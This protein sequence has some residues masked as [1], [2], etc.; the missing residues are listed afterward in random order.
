[1]RAQDTLA[2]RLR[3]RPA[4]PMGSPR[5]GSN[6]TG[7]AGVA[8]PGPGVNAGHRKLPQGAPCLWTP[9][10]PR[11]ARVMGSQAEPLLRPVWRHVPVSCNVDTLA[12]RLR[13]R[14]AKPMGSPRVGSN[15]TGVAGLA[16]PG[17]GVTAGHRKFTRHAPRLWTPEKNQAFA[18]VMGS[19]SRACFV[20]H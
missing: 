2:E 1:M 11:L 20:Q 16:A 17:P 9:E 3:R 8:A 15:P 14:P 12:E 4:K 10:K 5:V 13:R 6:P 7:V 18:G 19:K